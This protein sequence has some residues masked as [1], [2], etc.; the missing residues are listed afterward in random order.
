MTVHKAKGISD[1]GVAE[2]VLEESFSSDYKKF[3]GV[4]IAVKLSVKHDGKK[5]MSID[6]K[7]IEILENIDAK[8]FAI[9]D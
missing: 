2:E 8:E 5:F 9:D 7:D 3:N 1:S 4:M 6:C